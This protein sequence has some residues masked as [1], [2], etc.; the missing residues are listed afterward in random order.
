MDGGQAAGRLLGDPASLRCDHPER[1]SFTTVTHDR[2]YGPTPSPFPAM[3]TTRNGAW[4]GAAY[5]ETVSGPRACIMTAFARKFRCSGHRSPGAADEK[6]QFRGGG[7]DDYVP[8]RALCRL[9]T[10]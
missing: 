4:Q 7:A 9:R 6:S 5:R 8:C 1:S 10:P 3:R 2:R